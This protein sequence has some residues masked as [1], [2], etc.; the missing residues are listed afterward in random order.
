[1]ELPERTAR[2]FDTMIKISLYLP[3]NEE[4]AL[5]STMEQNLAAG[6]ALSA[7]FAR[8]TLIL[9]DVAWLLPFIDQSLQEFVNGFDYCFDSHRLRLQRWHNIMTSSIPSRVT[10]TPV[11]SGMEA[12]VAPR[13]NWSLNAVFTIPKKE[14]RLDAQGC[15][16]LHGRFSPRIF[17]LKLSV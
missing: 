10:A 9:T 1:M 7:S 16:S 2:N 12:K 5:R 8:S 14:L 11:G 3:D 15:I 13:G 4:R 17:G 6:L